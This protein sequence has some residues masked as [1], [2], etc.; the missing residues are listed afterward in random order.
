LKIDTTTLENHQVKLTVEVEIE[1][2]ESAK[3]RAARQIA[4]KTKIPGFRPGKAPYPVIVRQIGEAAI[5][6]EAIDLLV[7]DVY[8]KA[9]DE[10]GI[11]PYGPG[12]LE[13]V[14]SMEPP[15]FEFV[16]PLEAEVELGDFHSIR[17]TY[18]P[19]PVTEKQV[20]E[21]VEDLR[22]RQAILEPV[23]R[24]AQEGDVVYVRI[25][26]QRLNPDEGEDAN[27]VSERSVPI[28]IAPVKAPA[29]EEEDDSPE[30]WPFPG[31]SRNLIG[32]SVGDEKTIN[33][34]FSEESSYEALRGK[35]A[36][37]HYVVED[38]KSRTLPEL[39]DDFAM[40][41]GDF[42]NGDALRAEIRKELEQ[43]AE[44]E[45]NQDYDEAIIEEAVN[46]STIKFP[47]EMLEREIDYVIDN[48]ESRLSQQKVDLDLYLKSRQMEMDDLRE[49]SRPVAEKRLRQMLV[50]SKIA[51][52]EGI[53][54]EP[55]EL[56]NE[57]MRTVDSL[58]RV[59]PKKEA[60][61]LNQQRVLNN[62]VG[63]IMADLLT[64][65]AM[66]HLR[67]SSRGL[68]EAQSE[69]P[70]EEAVDEPTV[71]PP[72]DEEPAEADAKPTAEP[73]AEASEAEPA[74]D[75]SEPVAEVSGDSDEKE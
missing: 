25:D 44:E 7:Q 26:G 19:A 51:S 20:D 29:D 3:H 17:R 37:F 48:L 69:E 55:D 64:Q 66:S 24:P 12:K 14:A 16:I 56:Q 27:L 54:V 60:R 18:E 32:R 71:E 8:P 9:I 38:I 52:D 74:T 59:M 72:A 41:V 15:K 21:V 36:T 22:D 75:Q 2:L 30:E 23:T 31:F 6:E 50:L 61:K 45:Y 46:Q 68:L 1:T 35:E 33:H 11:H 13:N 65:K 63:N 10:A 28:L 58:Y 34:Q 39:N 42:E 70:A 62:L 47:P 5:L 43:R 57:T 40:T 53:E 67:D 49:E 4:K 73:Q